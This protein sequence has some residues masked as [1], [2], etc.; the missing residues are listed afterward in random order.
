MGGPNPKP[1]SKIRVNTKKG[2]LEMM[3]SPFHTYPAAHL[4]KPVRPRPW[5][6]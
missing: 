3:R 4:C 6:H 1:I 2:R 5:P